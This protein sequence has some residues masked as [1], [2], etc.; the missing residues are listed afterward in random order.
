[1]DIGQFIIYREGLP[2]VIDPGV[3]AY[4]RD[5]FG[6]NRYKNWFINCDGHNVPQ[7][8]G[9]AQSNHPERDAAAAEV[10]RDGKR[11]VFKMDLTS[12]YLPEAKLA[13]CLRTVTYDYTD[14]SVEVDD[15]WELSRASPAWL[16]WM[17]PGSSAAVFFPCA[18]LA[19]QSHLAEGE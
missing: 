1:M 16:R 8:N 18:C 3:G 17:L 6:P 15:V 2:V 13:K 4:S 9:I 12:A 7:F 19:E 5:T 14:Q 11:C 10:V